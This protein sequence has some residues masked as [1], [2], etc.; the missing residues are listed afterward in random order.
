MFNRN[1]N[2]EKAGLAPQMMSKNPNLTTTYDIREEAYYG[3]AEE[4]LAEEKQ[5]DRF[6]TSKLGFKSI[7]D[8]VPE[9]TGLPS[10]TAGVK[11]TQADGIAN[12]YNKRNP[13]YIGI[14]QIN[15]VNQG[16]QAEQ[17]ITKMSA[18]NRAIREKNF[19]LAEMLL[20]RPLTQD[21]LKVVT[22]GVYYKSNAPQGV[23]Y[24][25]FNIQDVTSLTAYLQSLDENDIGYKVKSTGAEVFVISG[26][27]VE[28]DLPKSI[29]INLSKSMKDDQEDDQSSEDVWEFLNRKKV[30]V[31]SDINFK[32]DELL[33]IASALR[34][35]HTNTDTRTDLLRIIKDTIFNT[36]ELR[37]K[38]TSRKGELASSSS[39]SADDSSSAVANV[40]AT[41][42]T[43]KDKKFKKKE[44]KGVDG[45]SNVVFV[46]DEDDD[47]DGLPATVKKQDKLTSGN[48]VRRQLFGSMSNSK[49][50]SQLDVTMGMLNAGNNSVEL[51]K[52]LAFLLQCMYDRNILSKYKM[53]RISKMYLGNI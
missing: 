11:V 18:I 19:Q 16:L 13:N 8:Q 45:S 3:E 28:K 1:P 41:T 21:D 39:S 14:E 10:V 50:K 20:G 22:S 33:R 37:G 12:G 53:T 24:K 6:Q 38:L 2:L 4:R 49:M 31:P 40:F 35:K 26:P 48:G 30:K 34:I 9:V 25:T 7:F 51:L 23:I 15:Y 5:Y 47:E 46:D 44:V 42:P 32:K 17:E 36:P 27:D 43:K 52:D 29:T